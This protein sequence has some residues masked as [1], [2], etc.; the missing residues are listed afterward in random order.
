LNVIDPSSAVPPVTLGL[1][2]KAIPYAP[3]SQPYL[4][5]QPVERVKFKP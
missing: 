3:K 4:V 2:T 5:G 1:P